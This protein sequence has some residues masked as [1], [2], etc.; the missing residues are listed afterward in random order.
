MK[1]IITAINKFYSIVRLGMLDDLTIHKIYKSLR[2][3]EN[4]AYNNTPYGGAPVIDTIKEFA[5]I[6]SS[7]IHDYITIAK[8][9]APKIIEKELK[10]KPSNIML[11]ADIFPFLN[12]NDQ[13]KFIKLISDD[14]IFTFVESA[15]FSYINY[16]DVLYELYTRAAKFFSTK[17][18]WHQFA[19]KMQTVA[20]YIQ[21]KYGNAG[22]EVPNFWKE[23]NIKQ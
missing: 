1:K 8:D 17:K 20:N 5:N 9:I 4:G 10:N 6:Q 12:H 13:L 21:D 7:D 15:P 19:D 3:K 14:A 2:E 18:D 11:L 16:S 22:V 23:M